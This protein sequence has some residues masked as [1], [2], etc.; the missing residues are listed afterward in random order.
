VRSKKA[1]LGLHAIFKFTGATNDEYVSKNH[2]TI[3]A[4]KAML[5]RRWRDG[6]HGDKSGPPPGGPRSIVF[7]KHGSRRKP[8]KSRDPDKEVAPRRKVEWST[9]IVD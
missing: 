1:C 3:S 4:P 2:E 8:S 7:R 5:H 6:R 9:S